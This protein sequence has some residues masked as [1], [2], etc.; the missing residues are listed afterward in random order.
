[1]RTTKTTK[2]ILTVAIAAL[3]CKLV[4]AV[5]A[6]PVP[7]CASA[8]WLVLA[9]GALALG[10]LALIRYVWRGPRPYGRTHHGPHSHEH[11]HHHN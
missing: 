5:I 4:S 8:V 6:V 1:M 7:T 9:A 3:T 10:A 11:E 2:T